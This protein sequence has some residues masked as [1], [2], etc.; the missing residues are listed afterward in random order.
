MPPVPLAK[1]GKTGSL[2]EFE[3]T[4]LTRQSIKSQP[5]HNPFNLKGQTLRP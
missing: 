5:L 2:V 3:L 1:A 4:H